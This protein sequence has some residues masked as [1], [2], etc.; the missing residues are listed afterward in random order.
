LLPSA[1]V[2]LLRLSA[3]SEGERLDIFRQLWPA[4][5]RHAAGHFVVVTD[6]RVRRSRLP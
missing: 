4:I 6:T 1:G 3:A 5:E 2:I